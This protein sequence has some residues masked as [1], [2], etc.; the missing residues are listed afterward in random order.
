MHKRSSLTTALCLQWGASGATGHEALGQGFRVR[1]FGFK[2]FG[3]L[4]SGGFNGLGFEIQGLGL[5]ALGFNMWEFLGFWCL[6][7]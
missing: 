3:S 5:R 6:A 4:G 2:G 1:V 7:R